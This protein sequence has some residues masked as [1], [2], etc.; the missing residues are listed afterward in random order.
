VLFDWASYIRPVAGLNITPWNPQ[1]ALAIALL[2]RR[3]RAAWLAFAGL[4]LSEGVVRGVGSAWLPAVAASAALTVTFLVM[5][6]AL[7]R[8]LDD[9]IPLARHG[10][11]LRFAAIVTAGSL[12]SALLYVPIRAAAW[13]AQA[14]AASLVLRYWVGD[15][16]ALLVTLPL[17]LALM[18]PERR[19]GMAEILRTGVWWACVALGALALGLIFGRGDQDYFK[20]FYLLLPPVVWAAVRFGVD[21]AV[22]ALLGTQ[23]GLLA[24]AQLTL[25]N[26]STFFELQALM[27]GT[28][29]T[30]LLLGVLVDE[31]ARAEAELRAHLRFSAAGQMAAALAH[32]LS[33]PITA[34]NNY[35]F[36]CRE[37]ALPGETMDDARRT[38]LA[39]VTSDL[40]AQAQRAGMVTRRLRDFFRTGAMS[41]QIAS[42]EALVRDTL[43]SHAALAER[44]GVG[45]AEEVEPALAPVRLDEIQIAVVLRNLVANAIE[46]AAQAPRPSVLVR[47]ARDGADVRVDVIDSGPGIHGERLRT[48]FEMPASDKQEGLGVGLRISRAIVEAHGG[49][50]WAQP[51]DHGRLSFTLPVTPAADA[52]S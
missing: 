42:V 22:L 23:L 1:Q 36:A 49:K 16:V 9:S 11:L 43:E 19:A 10:E 39:Q 30:V 5:S 52:A 20:F 33:Q 31:R 29:V 27:G 25:Q 32:E 14:S 51:G 17:V 7:G 40:V 45:L 15:A 24:S 26:D 18:S 3:P 21:G 44:L 13:P 50:L 12:A 28:A 6:R 48:I 35:A 38:Q 47:A 8:S 46:S 4:V 2:M 37:L 41:L 34:L